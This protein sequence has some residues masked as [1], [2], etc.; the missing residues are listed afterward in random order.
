MSIS[1]SRAK[2][3]RYSS[4]KIFLSFPY[5]ES[6]LHK[7]R[8]T[9]T[10]QRKKI[11]SKNFDSK[12]LIHWAY[13]GET[14]TDSIFS[15]SKWLFN[16]QNWN[17]IWWRCKNE[18]ITGNMTGLTWKFKQTYTPQRNPKLPSSIGKVM[19]MDRMQGDINLNIDIYFYTIYAFDN[20]WVFH[21]T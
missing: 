6:S 4:S 12:N 20:N 14:Q 7:S 18:V 16:C 3:Y 19:F 15:H 13:L 9:I 8:K 11:Y 5:L 10:I 21:D 1:H 17:L 2:T